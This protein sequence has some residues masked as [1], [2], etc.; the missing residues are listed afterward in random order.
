[1]I[2]PRY[3]RRL[4]AALAARGARM[5]RLRYPRPEAGGEVSAVRL[6]PRAPA[7]GRVVVA[8]GAGNDL[9]FPLIELFHALVPRGFEVFSFDLDGHG[10]ESTTTFSE[11]AID[12]AIPAA[13]RQARSVDPDLPLHLL[14]HSLGG[15]L[16]LRALAMRAVPNVAS[17]VI[18]SS[19][20]EVKL[21]LPVAIS[22][23]TGFLRTSTLA[24]RR[25]YGVWGLVPA[26]GPVKRRA[27][28]FRRTVDRA[29][30]FGYVAAVQRLLA[31]Y[32]LARSAESIDVPV[33]L[34]Y[35]R[36]DRLVPAAQG[37]RLARAIPDAELA[38]LDGATH[39]SCAFAPAALERVAG[40]MDRR[41][42]APA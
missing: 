39:W 13:V 36:G 7:R 6:V 4:E 40:W 25:H 42:P 32:D 34:V 41:T 33:L 26:F 15:S 19:P 3:L 22:E 23:L 29:G 35:G 16:V 5:E 28:P 31:R 20:V 24:Q 14:G 1:M 10:A 17:A 30:A 9:L 2:A 38:L 37:E 18:L 27:Y 12:G 11:E 21:D 8:H